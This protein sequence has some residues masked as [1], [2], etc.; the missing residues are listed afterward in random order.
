MTTQEHKTDE[1]R[2]SRTPWWLMGKCRKEIHGPMPWKLIVKATEDWLR[3]GKH[4]L[5]NL[6]VTMG[7]SALDNW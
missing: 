5:L 6:T 4:S 7:K 3:R 1:K 2:G